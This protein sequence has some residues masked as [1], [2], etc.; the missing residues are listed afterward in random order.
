MQVNRVSCSRRTQATQP[1]CGREYDTM[2]KAFWIAAAAYLLPTF[3]L[4]YGW[5]L[6][7]FHENYEQLGIYRQEVI[8][9]LG[10]LSMLIQAVLFAWAYPRLFSTQRD[11]WLS[12]ALQCGCAFGLIVG[13]TSSCP[14]PPST[15]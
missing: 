3:P 10:L 9:P 6:V 14:S 4:G 15:I 8:I 12:S 11:R 13:P 5:H 1:A 2:T 7:T